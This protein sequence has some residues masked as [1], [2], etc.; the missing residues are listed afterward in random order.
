M[1]VQVYSTDQL[2]VLPLTCRCPAGRRMPLRLAREFLNQQNGSPD[3]LVGTYRC[4]DCGHVIFIRRKHL[5]LAV[6]T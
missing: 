4:A 2:M 3:Q 5:A 1:T 6:S